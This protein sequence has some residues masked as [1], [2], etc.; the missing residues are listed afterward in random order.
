MDG[1]IKL[2]DT[3]ITNYGAVSLIRDSLIKKGVRSETHLHYIIIHRQKTMSNLTENL[4]F[5]EV[6]VTTKHRILTK[7]TDFLLNLT[8][9]FFCVGEG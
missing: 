9:H 6:S 1:S 3:I 4:C 7:R 8:D 5:C 2:L